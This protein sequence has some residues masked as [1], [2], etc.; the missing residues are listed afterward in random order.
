MDRRSIY[1]NSAYRSDGTNEDF[2]ITKTVQEFSQ[3]PQSAKM[4]SASIPFTWQNIVADNST[5]TITEVPFGPELSDDFVIPTGNYTSTTLATALETLINA[6]TVL[7]QTYT[8]TYDSATSMFTISTVGPEPFQISFVSPSAAVPLGFVESSTN[9]SSPALTVTST[10][11]IQ[12]MAD[13]EIFVCCD[14]VKG[15][16]N[17]VMIWDPLNDPSVDNQSQ[18]LARVPVTG[19]HGGILQ[20]TA[21]NDLPFYKIS[22]SAFARS[23]GAGTPASIRFFLMLPS[24]NTLDLGGYH[25]SIELVLDFS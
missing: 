19:C 4:I 22:Q 17:G 5:F 18:I 11:A 1:I 16:D 6:S 14:L 9:P 12:L 8:V 20:Y 7:A 10:A 23:I 24:G 15:S 21:P 13:Y 3:I 2:T 25:W